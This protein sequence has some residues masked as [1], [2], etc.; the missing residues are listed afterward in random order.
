MI[1]SGRIDYAECTNIPSWGE[2]P[3]H[4]L[5]RPGAGLG[6]PGSSPG[7]TSHSMGFMVRPMLAYAQGTPET[8]TASCHGGGTG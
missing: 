2:I 8:H 1:L 5:A 6:Q 7:T 4:R 3:T